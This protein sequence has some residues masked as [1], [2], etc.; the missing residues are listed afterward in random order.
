[1][2]VILTQSDRTM[3]KKIHSRKGATLAGLT[4]AVLLI[5]GFDTSVK[6]AA[7]TP[8]DD[9]L[10]L[11]RQVESPSQLLWT[12]R[13]ENTGKS[14]TELEYEN[15][16]TLNSGDHWSLLTP[17][18]AFA[19]WF[20]VGLF[21]SD[22]K[23]V[24]DVVHETHADCEGGSADGLMKCVK[25][26]QADC[27]GVWIYMTD[28]GSEIWADGYNNILNKHGELAEFAGCNLPGEG[29]QESTDEPEVV[30]IV[31]A[32]KIIGKKH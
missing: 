25:K 22:D 31:K 8:D 29:L 6:P 4:L 20:A 27:D 16:G 19:V 18:E 23:S 12:T 28:D 3:N 13:D 1:M 21:G 14:W 30:A 10:A 26:L 5:W 24:P 7:V 32:L 2:F 11:I 9:L 17:K 15:R